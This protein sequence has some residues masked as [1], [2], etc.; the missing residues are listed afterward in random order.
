M[1]EVLLNSLNNPALG[2]GNEFNTAPV[3]WEY[4]QENR[5]FLPVITGR[6]RL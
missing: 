2:A 6:Q 4:R 3:R 5:S 1:P